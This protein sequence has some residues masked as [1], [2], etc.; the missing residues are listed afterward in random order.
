LL[1]NIPNAWLRASLI[2]A[3]ALLQLAVCVAG[4]YRRIAIA[5][6]RALCVAVDS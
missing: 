4:C 5:G 2:A 3:S 6:A 1:R